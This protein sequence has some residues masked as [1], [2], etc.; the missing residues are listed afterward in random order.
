MA[1]AKQ[2]KRKLTRGNN[3]DITE[4]PESVSKYGRPSVKHSVPLARATEHDLGK[5]G[6]SDELLG[7]MTN[8]QGQGKVQRLSDVG[9]F[10]EKSS[11]PYE[12]HVGR[13]ILF[14]LDSSEQ[15]V[16]EQA[17]PYSGENESVF[18]P[19]RSRSANAQPR[20]VSSPGKGAEKVNVNSA[21]AEALEDL[22]GI[23]PA[24]AVKIMEFRNLH[25]P[26]TQFE[27]ITAVRGVSKRL[28]RKLQPRLTL[29]NLEEES[30][31]SKQEVKPAGSRAAA[32]T[33][34]GNPS[35]SVGPKYNGQDVVRVG[36]WNLLRLSSDKVENE[37]VREVVCRTI[38][39]NG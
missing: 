5:F 19:P 16:I 36:S 39:E 15:V 8:L 26:F 34:S 4:E 38:L 2:L 13:K 30:N 24:L 37:G 28:I 14:R 9:V 22:N 11:L 18:T 20:Q 7:A 33:F 27:E 21:S 31:R 29:D 35:K 10:L 12:V 17:A 25:G 3:G 6:A 32:A 23:G 1:H